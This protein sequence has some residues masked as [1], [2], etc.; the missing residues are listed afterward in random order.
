MRDL[1]LRWVISSVYEQMAPD[2]AG[3]EERHGYE[4]CFFGRNGIPDF[5]GGGGTLPDRYRCCKTAVCESTQDQSEVGDNRLAFFTKRLI[6]MS[7]PMGRHTVGGQT[8]MPDHPCRWPYRET[9]L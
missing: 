6:Q 1:S 3:K 8:L 7:Q 4:L 9:C 2:S 5:C